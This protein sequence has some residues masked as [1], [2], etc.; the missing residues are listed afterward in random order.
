MD[1]PMTIYLKR[2]KTN[3]IIRISLNDE[4]NSYIIGR[5]KE[6]DCTVSGNPMIS[7]QHIEI[8]M[9]G[10]NLY[11]GDLGSKFLTFLDDA[12][13]TEPVQLKDSQ[14]LKLADELFTIEINDDM[15]SNVVK[16]EGPLCPICHSVLNESDKF[17]SVCGS[18][19]E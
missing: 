6:C 1:K 15:N 4:D 18:F 13:V 2:V 5:S 7:R 9:K 17:C 3:E 16:E 19:I 14:I 11:I 8:T 12:Q 10:G